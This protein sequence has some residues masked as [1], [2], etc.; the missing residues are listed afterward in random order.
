[1]V[2]SLAL[3]PRLGGKRHTRRVVT[4]TDEF[5]LR[6]EDRGFSLMYGL[7]VLEKPFSFNNRQ[8]IS[9]SYLLSLSL[10]IA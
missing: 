7:G 6:L 10:A 5:G 2:N 3:Y 4:R 1:M 9:L 8:G